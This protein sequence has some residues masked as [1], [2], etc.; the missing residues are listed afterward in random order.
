MST[1]DSQQ[2]DDGAGA[3]AAAPA[4]DSAFYP[5]G[6]ADSEAKAAA[7]VAEAGVPIAGSAF[8][9]GT[10]FMGPEVEAPMIGRPWEADFEAP[11]MLKSDSF[12]Q[13][14]LQLAYSSSSQ[15]STALAP[16]ISRASA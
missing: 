13:V 8:A 12:H 3:A 2:S 16:S 11:K 9:E 15:P 14:S 5:V 1:A 10:K 7:V 6:S 4:G